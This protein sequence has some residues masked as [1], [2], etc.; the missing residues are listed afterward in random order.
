[1][2]NLL[3]GIISMNKDALK[4]EPYLKYVYKD[5]GY[6]IKC[7]GSGRHTPWYCI[8]R[9]MSE[10]DGPE[11]VLISCLNSI[12]YKNLNKPCL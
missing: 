6:E 2:K 10:I 11:L 3:E 12:Y 7:Y 5:K 8:T 4:L 1:M 9:E